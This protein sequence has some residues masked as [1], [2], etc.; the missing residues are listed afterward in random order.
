MD[1]ML[2]FRNGVAETMDRR[3]NV[4]DAKL[5]EHDLRFEALEFHFGSLD[6]R[7]AD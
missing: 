2:D 3:F 7:V 1:A 5:A 6:R 4:V